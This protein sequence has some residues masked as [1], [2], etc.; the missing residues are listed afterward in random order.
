MILLIQ[1]RKK[2]GQSSCAVIALISQIGQTPPPSVAYSLAVEP[3]TCY[4]SLPAPRIVSRSNTS[5]TDLSSGN[6]RETIRAKIVHIKEQKLKGKAEFQLGLK[7]L[8]RFK[9]FNLTVISFFYKSS[10]ELFLVHGI[11]L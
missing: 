9:S 7:A 11:S 8:Q 6:Q 4:S 3:S 1:H 5:R 10:F 2:S